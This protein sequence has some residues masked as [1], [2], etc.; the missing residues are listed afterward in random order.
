[1]QLDGGENTDIITK[2]SEKIKN[3]I[4]DDDYET[5]D[6]EGLIQC[7][8]YILVLAASIVYT[9]I[10][11][12]KYLKREFT[13][14][15][16]ILLGPISCIT[17][18]IDK[19]GDGKAQAYNR[20]L[21]EFI[22]QVLIQPFHLLIYVVL[23]GSASELA[24]E[25]ILYAIACFAVMIPAEKFIKEMFGFRD[26]LG[27][28]LGSFASGALASKA[29]DAIK[30]HKGKS[31]SGGDSKKDDSDENDVIPPKTVDKDKE[32]G[33]DTSRES[34]SSGENE[35]NLV[36]QQLGE[37][38]NNPH[39]GEN[40]DTNSENQPNSDSVSGENT[41][42]GGEGSDAESNNLDANE[43]GTLDSNGSNN[44]EENTLNSN[45]N[46]NTEDPLNNGDDNNTGENNNN[47][48]T[49]NNKRS[50]YSRLKNNDV[51][52]S[53]R[54]MH[55]QRMIKKYGS[56]SKKQRNIKRAKKLGKG[57]WTLTKGT[58]KYGSIAA[59]ATGGAALL[60]M[61]GKSKEAK[62]LVTGA[63]GIIGGGIGKNAS[64][65]VK[66][67]ITWAKG[68]IKD[69]A[70][71]GKSADEDKK[72]KRAKEK[73]MNDDKKIKLAQ[74]SFKKRTGKDATYEELKE[75]LEDRFELER[76]E[77]EDKEIDKSLEKLHELEDAGLSKEDAL[78]QTAFAA[79]LAFN[80]DLK[81]TDFAD[82]KKMNST[83]EAMA[84]NAIEDKDF[85]G[86]ET[87]K[88]EA[89]ENARM[90][91]A[92][93]LRNAANIKKADIVLPDRYKNVRLG[94]GRNA[95]ENTI[96]LERDRINKPVI[97]ALGIDEGTTHIKLTPEQKD[98][99]NKL[100]VKLD[101]ATPEQIVEISSIAQKF[102]V[103]GANTDQLIDSYEQAVEFIS[104]SGTKNTAIEIID[105]HKGITG[106][107]SDITD[108][109]VFA[110]KLE[111]LKASKAYN[112]D[113]MSKLEE[114]RGY[115]QAFDSKVVE[116]AR[117]FATEN[118][119]K[120][121]GGESI[122]AEGRALTDS[123]KSKGNISKNKADRMAKDAIN[124]SRIGLGKA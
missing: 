39:T 36:P 25:N 123:I 91:A 110:E 56:A 55:N 14:I 87:K 20:W 72:I 50:K 3:I 61:T 70:P 104:D 27:S 122:E 11:L 89:L 77:L 18:P 65:G 17:Y 83:I 81:K 86:D 71:L 24:S 118:G 52:K 121:L 46:N 35:S 45:E 97:T 107:K 31:S 84:Q 49:P 19:I 64:E 98:K 1:M 22:Y 124:L 94:G 53:L 59:I 82:E 105:T 51:A 90:A 62:G 100:T 95:G 30:N 88:Q 85:G 6:G 33:V 106:D 4:D 115:E 75:E 21:T 42:D 68:A 99:I 109:E 48:D 96:T 119:D 76:R 23:I 78:D 92:Y 67:T 26:N 58:L 108:K 101:G 63:A 5:D 28:P 44:E 114:V 117:K 15:F 54:T 57:L 8:F 37:E 111:M 93:H 16:L 73:Y 60:A 38:N 13:I 29:I 79:D 10:F 112:I 102:A 40:S 113:K 120:I 69:Y 32:M 9:L 116:E 7:Y 103:D 74:A 41:L 66:R 12:M 2:Y 34:G 43:D 47:G 80:G